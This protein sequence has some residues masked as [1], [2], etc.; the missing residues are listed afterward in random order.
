[1]RIQ[2]VYTLTLSTL[3]QSTLTPKRNP[4]ESTKPIQQSLTLWDLSM[5]LCIARKWCCM[6]RR[7][8]ISWEASWFFWLFRL[9]YAMTNLP[10]SR[11]F[12]SSI[13]RRVLFC[14]RYWLDLLWKAFNRQWQLEQTQWKRMWQKRW[15]CDRTKWKWPNHLLY[16]YYRGESLAL[17]HA[18]EVCIYRY[19]IT[20]VCMWLKPKNK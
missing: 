12:A 8:K 16:V 19:T 11:H 1:M 18:I 17:V 5:H 9:F 3:L 13:A 7:L 6:W 2:S 20:L 15:K 10:N 4:C 14:I